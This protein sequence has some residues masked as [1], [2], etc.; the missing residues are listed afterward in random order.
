[1]TGRPQPIIYHF[2]ITNRPEVPR[3][4]QLAFGHGAES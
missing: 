4:C 3:P 1:M 2:P